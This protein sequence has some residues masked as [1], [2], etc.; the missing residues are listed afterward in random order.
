MKRDGE[1][2]VI[3]TSLISLG[4]SSCFCALRDRPKEQK[5]ISFIIMKPRRKS[6]VC[7]H[8]SLLLYTDH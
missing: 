8:Q 6:S 7:E 3:H 2:S 5:I 1:A 4:S